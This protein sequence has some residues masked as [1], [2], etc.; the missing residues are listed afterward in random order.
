MDAELFGKNILVLRKERKL[1]QEELANLAGVSRNYISMIERG[2]AE[3]V[4]DDVIRKLAIGL[5]VSAHQLTGEPGEATTVMIPPTLRE[6]AINEG[7]NYIIV[8]KLMQIP[9]RGKEPGSAQ[10]WKSLYEA[11]KPF[12]SGE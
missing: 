1:T 12:I 4:S 11:I 5:E 8:E 9:R 3:N 6:F 10:E 2:E 7:L